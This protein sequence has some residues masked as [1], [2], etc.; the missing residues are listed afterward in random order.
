MTR[1]LGLV[2]AL[3]VAAPAAAQVAVAPI[4]DAISYGTAAANPTRV[5][6][7]VL[8]SDGDT[9]AK[10]C[11]LAQLAVSEAIGNAVA[12]ALKAIVVAPRPCAG[13]AP[14]GMPSGHTL[15]SA[16]GLQAGGPRAIAF[17]VATGALRIAAHRHTPTQVV[18]GAAAGLVA[19]R[20][21]RVVVRCDR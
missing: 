7:D 9:P 14:D 17:V 19:D 1:A 11:R 4:P 2:V 20:L 3:V 5:V 12:I 8:R 6:V 15:N 16:I 21:G 18:A 10:A 13:C